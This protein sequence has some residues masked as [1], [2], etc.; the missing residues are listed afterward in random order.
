MNFQNLNLV[1]LTTW[2]S[3]FFIL[4]GMGLTAS[5]I[6]PLN[7]CMQLVGIIGWLVVACTHQPSYCPVPGMASLCFPTWRVLL[8]IFSRRG[9]RPWRKCS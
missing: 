1:W 7:M 3:S 8:W 6:Y 5:H 4:A 9:K 2:V